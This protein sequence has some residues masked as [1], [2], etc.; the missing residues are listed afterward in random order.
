MG[1]Q[2]EAFFTR[3]PFLQDQSVPVAQEE[4]KELQ[5]RELVDQGNTQALF[6][7]ALFQ[8]KKGTLQ[9][10]AEAALLLRLAGEYGHAEAQ[11]KL[12]ECFEQGR[13]VDFDMVEAARRYRLAADLGN[14]DSQF[15]LALCFE[16][17]DGVEEDMTEAVKLY[18]LAADRGHTQSQRR[19][20]MLYDQGH[21]VQKD[22]EESFRYSLLAA[23][24]GIAADQCNLA[25]KYVLAIGTARNLKE[26]QKWFQLAANQGSAEAQLEFAGFYE[27]QRDYK[28]ASRL[29]HL[30]AAQGHAAA[31]LALALRY[32]C[33]GVGLELDLQE[34]VRRLRLAA[35]QGSPRAR[36]ILEDHARDPKTDITANRAFAQEQYN[37]ALYF[38]QEKNVKAAIE[39]CRLAVENSNH[40]QAQCMLAWFFFEGIG[41]QQDYTEAVRLYR[42]AAAQGNESAQVQLGHCYYEGLGVEKDPVEA[43]RLFRLP[44]RET[45]ALYNLGVCY[46]SGTGVPKDPIEAFRLYQLAANKGDVLAQYRL[47]L[48]LKAPGPRQNWT[49]AA[50]MFRLA[51]EA[52]IVD[53]M[54]LYG[55]CVMEGL[56]VQRDPELATKIFQLAARKGHVQAQFALYNR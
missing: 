14:L 2:P 7:L 32:Y 45:R 6:D 9:A 8:Q 35:E 4:R 5:L 15:S 22:P 31:N 41:V 13:G 16:K 39:L 17:G 24:S 56:G 50:R 1:A 53:A 37:H 38:H 25:R 30:A 46:E 54:F 49:E 43:V 29:F 18:R 34:A 51:A 23:E 55:V 21:K 20:V 52:D 40:P 3:V 28:E 47:G 33:T 36:A 26:A 12:A 44:V 48:M 11:G 42:L 19:L 10:L 27:I